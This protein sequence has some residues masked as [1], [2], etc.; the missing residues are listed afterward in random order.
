[1]VLAWAPLAVSS[2]LSL[3]NPTGF[4]FEAFLETTTVKEAG[5]LARDLFK[6]LGRW[7]PDS[8][9]GTATHGATILHYL[10]V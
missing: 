5:A 8:S 7:K 6:A 2:A 1:M 3:F 4:P 9:A 10:S